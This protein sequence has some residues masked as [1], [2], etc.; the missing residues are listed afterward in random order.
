MIS[1]KKISARVCCALLLAAIWVS[2]C[3]VKT[4]L[5]PDAVLN[6][7]AAIHELRAVLQNG[8]WLV[9]R[10]VHK[11]DNLV[12]TMTNMPLSH[13]SLYDAAKDGVIEAEGSGV[14]ETLLVDLLA[15]S[16]R[17][18]IIRPMW[19]TEENARIAVARARSWIGKGYNFTGLVGINS[20][21]RYYCT[22]LA[23]EAYRP[24]IT[25]KPDNP[26]PLV[27][28]PGRMYHWGKILYDSGP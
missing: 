15:K 4:V 24:F 13:A 6:P 5:T 7:E 21:N 19:A 8:D 9:T 14:H 18:M 2:G 28:A 12:A 26:I 25:E 22:Q 3:T 17:V 27:I 20:P 1:I 11:T 23:I 16:S 10:G